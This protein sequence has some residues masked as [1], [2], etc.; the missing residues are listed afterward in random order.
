MIDPHSGDFSY[1]GIVCANVGQA[2]EPDSDAPVD[3]D[4]GAGRL[5]SRTYP[6]AEA[7]REGSASIPRALA[8]SLPKRLWHSPDF[9]RST[10]RFSR[11]SGKH[12]HQNSRASSIEAGRFL[13][14]FIVVLPGHL[15]GPCQLLLRTSAVAVTAA[16]PQGMRFFE[17]PR[18]PRTR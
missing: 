17:P 10:G 14:W 13:P 15:P 4:C 7:R 5:E 11:R 2:F 1:K 12:S 9:S 3:S 16:L 18:A 8:R 6:A